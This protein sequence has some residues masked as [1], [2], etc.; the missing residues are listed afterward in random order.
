MTTSRFE[1]P[2]NVGAISASTTKVLDLTS[3]ADIPA[4]SKRYVVDEIFVLNQGTGVVTLYVPG[5]R[6]L[7]L[8]PGTPNPL[9]VPKGIR[10]LIFTTDATAVADKKLQLILKGE[11]RHAGR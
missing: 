8:Q 1:L 10:E 2:H 9:M 11:Y 3:A 4:M 7:Y 5:S 6:T